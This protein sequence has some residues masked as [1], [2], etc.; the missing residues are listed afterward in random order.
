MVEIDG[1]QHDLSSEQETRRTRFLESAGYR[2]LRF[3]NNEVLYN[4][5]G[6][7]SVIAENLH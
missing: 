4:A 2:V 7:L 6:V 1:G 3:W 5:E